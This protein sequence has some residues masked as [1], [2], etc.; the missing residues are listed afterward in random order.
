VQKVRVA[1]AAVQERNH[2]KQIGLAVQNIND[3][4][5]VLP[6]LTAYNA[7]TRI[8]RAAPIYN[9][10]YGL[11]VF[12]WLL[13]FIE[14]DNVFKAIDPDRDDEGG[15]E[16]QRVIKTCLSPLDPSISSDGKC[17][18]TYGDST[19]WAASSFGANYYAFGNPGLPHCEGASRIPASFPDGL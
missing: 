1:A 5:G 9:G 16:Y 13:P 15:L 7:F 2:L 12:H 17:Q 19:T 11:T 3:T 10:P 14:Q 18:T 6:P 8:S 4:N